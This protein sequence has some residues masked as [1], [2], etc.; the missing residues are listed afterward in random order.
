ML[1]LSILVIKTALHYRY[2]RPKNQTFVDGRKDVLPPFKKIK[3]DQT[4]W[5][6]AA[7][8]GI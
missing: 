3:P 1:F 8:L 2:F 7:S 5:F 6:H 4:I